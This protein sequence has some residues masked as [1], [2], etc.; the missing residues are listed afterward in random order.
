MTDKYHLTI[1]D[2]KKNLIE[3]PI[4]CIDVSEDRKFAYLWM[5]EYNKYRLDQQDITLIK[6]PSVT[7]EAATVNLINMGFGY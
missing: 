1:S 4:K 5:Y 7:S 2:I 3:S 6:D